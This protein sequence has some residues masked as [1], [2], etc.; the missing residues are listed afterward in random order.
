MA[1]QVRI[2]GVIHS[3]ASVYFKLAGERFYGIKSISY[4]DSRSR[5]KGYGMGRHYAPRGRTSGK[6]EVDPVAVTCEKAT[7]KALRDKAAQLAGGS[8]FGN[9]EFEIVVQYVEAGNDT[10]TDTIEQ[11]TFSKEAAKA[12]E[13]PDPTVEDLEFDAMRIK[14][15]GLTLYD[16]S[17]GNP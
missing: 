3:W 8:S 16:T 2:N 15:N 6:Y 13:N 17:E 10:I 11:C 14:W 1:D 5:S 7:A 9:A 4:G 12:E